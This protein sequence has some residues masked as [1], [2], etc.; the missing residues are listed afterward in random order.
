MI[1]VLLFIYLLYSVVMSD[2]L[3]FFRKENPDQTARIFSS[4]IL[5]VRRHMP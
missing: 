4:Q 2:M 3:I 1:F 5:T